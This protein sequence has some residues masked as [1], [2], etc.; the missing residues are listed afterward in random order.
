MAKARAAEDTPRR[1]SR[2]S[3]EPPQ[4]HD[5][6]AIL[7]KL[8]EA[9]NFDFRSYKRATVYRRILR[10]VQDRRLKNLAAYSKYLDAHPAEYDTLL[11]SIFIKPT[12]F[13]RDTETWDILSTTILPKMLSAP[14][15]GE[16]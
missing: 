10:R 11:G 8:R 5:F 9:R 1:A 2:K 15:P 12:S 14:R 16:A 7:H 6:E 3:G 13:F 4:R